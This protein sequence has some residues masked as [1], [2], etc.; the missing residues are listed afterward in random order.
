LSGPGTRHEREHE[1]EFEAEYGLPEALPAGERL[2]WQASPRFMRVFVDV[3]HARALLVWFGLIVVVR[4]FEQWTDGES[5]GEML[6]TLIALVPVFTLSVVLFAFIAWLVARTTVYTLTDRRVVLRIGIVLSLTF[7]IPLSRV[8][9]ADVR[10]ASDGGG[11][12]AL[13]LSSD[14]KIAYLN[15][16]PHARPWC[17]SQPQPMLRGL[18]KVGPV[19]ALLRDAWQARREAGVAAGAESLGH[20]DNGSGLGEHHPA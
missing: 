9:A 8:I 16:W 19:S 6:G 14:D 11:D 3:F 1:H 12:I 17:W 5:A 2:L 13:R 20:P 18:A 10:A 7:N 4:L 15:L